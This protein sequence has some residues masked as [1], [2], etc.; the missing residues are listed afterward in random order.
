MENA[1]VAAW[2]AQV[3]PARTW[4]VLKV[5]LGQEIAHMLP[6]GHGDINASLSGFPVLLGLLCDAGAGK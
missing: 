2:K 3:S 4:A 1:L 5:A 6:T